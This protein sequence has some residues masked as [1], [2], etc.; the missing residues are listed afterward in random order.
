M[1]RL[2]DRAD[3]E[4]FDSNNKLATYNWAGLSTWFCNL[5]SSDSDFMIVWMIPFILRG[6]KTP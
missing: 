6:K 2:K 3:G 5:L 1:G 4:L